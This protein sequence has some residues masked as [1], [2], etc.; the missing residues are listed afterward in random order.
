MRGVLIT[1][2]L[3]S[4][5]VYVRAPELLETPMFRVLICV[6]MYV[7][8][9]RHLCEHVYVYMHTCMYILLDLICIYTP[10]T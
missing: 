3:L 7:H 8:V 2:A 10:Q 6:H 4:F 5:Q 9:Y 1:R